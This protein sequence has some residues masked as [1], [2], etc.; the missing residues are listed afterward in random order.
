[1]SHTWICED[2]CRNVCSTAHDVLHIQTGLN[3]GFP[4]SLSAHDPLYSWHVRE[5]SR[6]KTHK[7]S[8]VSRVVVLLQELTSLQSQV[9]GDIWHNQEEHTRILFTCW[10]EHFQWNLHTYERCTCATAWLLLVAVPTSF[11]V[12]L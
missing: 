2:P 5:S 4:T 1:M 10:N 9:S 3:A 11:A 8:Q 7:L 12:R 6:K